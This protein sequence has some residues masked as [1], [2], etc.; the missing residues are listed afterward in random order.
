[1]RTADAGRRGTRRGEPATLHASRPPGPPHG[2]AVNHAETAAA[3]LLIELALAED[4]GCPPDD[5]TSRVMVG[6]DQRGTVN[7]VA[8]HEG[9]LAGLPILELVFERLDPR[10]TMTPRLTDGDWLDEGTVIATF[11]GPLRSLLTG[12]RT[13]LN[14]ATHLSGVASLTRRYVDIVGKAKA[15]VLDTRKTHPGY[16][17]LEKY[18]VRQGGGQNHRM[19]L[20]DGCL[21]KDNHLAAWRAEHPTAT[22]ADAV[23]AARGYLT[24]AAMIEVE[25]DTLDQLAEVL[26]AA[27]NIVLLDNFTTEQLVRAVELRDETQSKALLEASGGVNLDTVHRIAL[28]GVDRISVGALTHSAKALDLAFDWPTEPA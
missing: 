13:A 27:P 4:L 15:V 7:L 8:R 21:I 20:H 3:N 10:V 12:E 26:P 14:F 2:P 18:A 1:M 17:L 19:G 16:R 25:V 28:T 9:V 24:P 23:A 22:L 6:E 11:T 5:V